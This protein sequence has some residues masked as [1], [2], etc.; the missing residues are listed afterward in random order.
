MI[1]QTIMKK[2]SMLVL[3]ILMMGIF[4]YSSEGKRFIAKYRSNY[5]PSDCRALVDR[6]QKAVEERYDDWR[7]ECVEE[8]LTIE[9]PFTK[10]EKLEPKNLRPLM[11]RELANKLVLIAK[12]SNDETLERID[13]VKV[14]FI[15]DDLT[16]VAHTQGEELAKF[17]TL[18]EEK[19][20]IRHLQKT[21]KVKEFVE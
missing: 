8:V 2:Y 5:I 11:Y 7:F 4:I 19:N 1:W 10:P 14:K 6:T 15:A 12:F 13:K 16:I 21:V 3:G 17:Q 9:I 18:R 20:I